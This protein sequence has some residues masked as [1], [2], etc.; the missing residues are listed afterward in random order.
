MALDYDPFSRYM[1]QGARI[2]YEQLTF[3][4]GASCAHVACGSGQV[5]LWAAR[6]E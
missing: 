2:F 6:M 1:E 5:A 3:P 4:L